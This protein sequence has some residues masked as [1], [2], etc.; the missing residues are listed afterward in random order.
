M[1]SDNDAV[2]DDRR[3][4]ILGAQDV[5]QVKLKPASSMPPREAPLRLYRYHPLQSRSETIDKLSCKHSFIH[6]PV[7]PLLSIC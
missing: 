6:S 1:E 7:R 5:K 3:Q 2:P 4:W